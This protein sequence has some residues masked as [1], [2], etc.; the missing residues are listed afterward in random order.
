MLSKQQSDERVDRP[1]LFRQSV[2][3]FVWTHAGP[4]FWAGAVLGVGV[5]LAVASI[6]AE[7][8][9]LT[10]QRKAWVSALGIILIGLSGIALRAA[11]KHQP[12]AQQVRS[13]NP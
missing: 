2:G 13:G 3:W 12:G 7:Y 4:Q 10:P 5:G 11:V 6:L 9:L 1:S 8:E